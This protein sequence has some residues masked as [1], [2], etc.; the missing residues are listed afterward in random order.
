M[1]F[2]IAI[3]GGGYIAKAD[4][5]KRFMIV[6]AITNIKGQDL[7]VKAVKELTEEERA[8]TLFYVVGSYNT[9]E[10]YA[11]EIVCEV[12]HIPQIKLMGSL[13]RAE[14]QEIYAQIDVVIVPSREETMSIVA[15]E[16]MMYGKVCIVSENTGIAAYVQDGINGFICKTGDVESLKDKLRWVLKNDNQLIEMGKRARKIYEEHFTMERFGEDLIRILALNGK[17]K[18]VW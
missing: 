1:E 18:I 2:Q 3:L 4:T 6:G 14:M 5:K 8:G 11:K 9:Q 10:S 17:E 13:S 7:L 12:D 15:T 16:G